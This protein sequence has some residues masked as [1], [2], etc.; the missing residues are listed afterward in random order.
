[1]KQNDHS[2]RRFLR[3]LGMTLGASGVGAFLPQLQLIRA[4]AADDRALNGYRAL[5][6]IY[7]TGGNDSWNMLMPYD[8]ARHAVYT[9]ARGGV[10]SAANGAGLAIDRGR[11]GTP[12]QI[13]DAATG[14]QY[15][16]NPG[17][18][19]YPEGMS[20]LAT[21]YRANKLAFVANVGT[22]VKP[23]TKAQYQNGS[24]PLP[25]NLYAHDA[26]ERLWHLAT[27]SG[28][29]YGWGG[30]VADKVG[31]ENGYQTLSPSIALDGNLF[32]S[33]ID[34]RNYALGKDG[35]LSLTG[36]DPV[37]S[38]SGGG[39]RARA[40]DRLLAEQQ[41]ASP[42]G[43]EYART[44]QRGRQLYTVLDAALRSNTVT[45]AFPDTGFGD[46]LR[47]IARMIKA[48]R[49]PAGTLRHKRQIY[50]VRV[51][52][53]DMHD[54]LMA[55]DAN[56]HAG[57]LADLSTALDAFWRA[58]NEI[59]AHN[60]VTTFTMSE[61]GRTLS[62]NGDGSDHAWGGVQMVMG[63]AVN[64]GRLYGS[65]PAQQ[66]DGPVSLARGQFIPAVSVDQ[67]A[68]TLAR[69]MGVTGAAELGTIFPNL[70][71]FPTANLGFMAA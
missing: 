13:S 62:S 61:F 1:M 42:L 70:A 57:H 16:L 5:V 6:C 66:L 38:A 37:A 2:R 47:T 21:L 55:D 49:D 35:L 52:H 45:T 69:W 71:N 8:A 25:P 27:A 18:D 4:A 68:A 60:E 7:L 40:V 23:L 43:Q 32:G 30:L 65:F 58:L 48:S 11:L 26:Q 12:V 10:H 36:V 22:L 41:T 33:G 31:I 53:F 56:G 14:A 24:V 19:L 34:T 67:M 17:N 15:A 64:G 20:K 39:V 29:A 46:R 3:T 28:G 54:G 9:T 59:G 51:G 44:F 63:G 50:F